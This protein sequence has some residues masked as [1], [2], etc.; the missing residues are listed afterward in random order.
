MALSGIA[1]EI[2]LDSGVAEIASIT[3]NKENLKK[4]SLEL[5]QYNKLHRTQ[6]HVR[7]FDHKTLYIKEKVGKV[8]RHI[9]LDLSLMDEKPVRVRDFNTTTLIASVIVSI[10]AFITF[11]IGS[12]GIIGIPDIYLYSGVAT[13]TLAS[14]A[15]FVLTARSYKDAWVFLT[16]H[17]KAPVLNL[18]NNVPNKPAFRQF[19]KSLASNIELARSNN[20]TSHSKLMPA[21]VGEHRRLLEKQ[22]ITE[23]Q[24]EQAKK[25]IL[26]GK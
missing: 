25:N 5:V 3:P 26:S 22:F 10:L 16:A 23:Q 11:Y 20:G 12:K 13:L 24:F 19:T 2:T 7:V 14:I 21:I 1:E 9:L 4:V 15:C 18:L 6:R 8:M 17:G